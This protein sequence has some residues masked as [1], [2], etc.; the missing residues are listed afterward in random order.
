MSLFNKLVVK[1]LPFI[2]KPVVGQV[3]KRYIAGA[4]LSDAIRTIKDLHAKSCMAT[5]DLLGEDIS[6]KDEA[7]STRE[8]VLQM[9]SAIAAERLNS[10]V[11]IK[12]TQFGLRIDKQLCYRN[13]RVIAR[14]A[15]ELN[16]FLRI[17][18]E[19]AT[20]T[21]DTLKMYHRL[22]SEGFENVG[23][24]I[25]AYLF[26]SE[27]DIREL[28]KTKANIR[29][30]KGIY[31]E[32][33][34]IAIKDRQGIRDNFMKLLRLALEGESYAGIATHD[35]YLVEQ[36]YQCL[37]ELKLSPKQYEF[38]MLLGVR[39]DLRSKIV[40]DGHRLRVYVPY[41]E[42]WYAYSIRRL[43]ENPAMAGYIVKAMFGMKS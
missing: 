17:D 22:R 25:Q 23:V 10:N 26:R 28:V 15:K 1:S 29:L 20:T 4:S 11:S 32:S 19:D 27:A 5:L 18:M 12:P 41:G 13:I 39:E 7:E 6:T 24:V 31:V 3:S 21:D 9:Y 37:R 40:A 8:N 34:S 2:P 30:C 16:N 36:S 43:K 38:Q 42:R 14:R 35:E 33:P